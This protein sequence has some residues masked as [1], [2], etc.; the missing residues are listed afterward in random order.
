[1]EQRLKESKEKEKFKTLIKFFDPWECLKVADFL[2]KMALNGWGFQCRKGI[3][4]KFKKITPKKI[5]Y[6]VEPSDQKSDYYKPL[7]DFVEYCKAAG[8][9]FVDLNNGTY[10]FK[11]E[12][13]DVVSISTDDSLKFR[14]IKKK[15]RKELLNLTILCFALLCTFIL[16]PLASNSFFSDTLFS[17]RSIS[18]P[19]IPFFILYPL[20]YFF[21]YKKWFNVNKKRLAANLNLIYPYEKTDLF[22]KVVNFIYLLFAFL[23]MFFALVQQD[24][25]IMILSLI[26]GFLIITGIFIFI[27]LKKSE[28]SDVFTYISTAFMTVFLI[29]CFFFISVLFSLEDSQYGSEFNGSEINLKEEALI[30]DKDTEQSLFSNKESSTIS[31]NEG[32]V[33]LVI[34]V[35]NS[36]YKS[37]M[38]LCFAELT[39]DTNI[40]EVS[41]IPGITKYGL[42]KEHIVLQSDD[43]IYEI[44]YYLPQSDL[45]DETTI[46]KIIASF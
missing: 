29:L 13:C 3:F 16:F 19:V 1:M 44:Y 22:F 6:A 23:F 17:I 33:L 5:R 25:S 30:L 37:L 36:S 26:S 42:E 41:T 15:T 2:E 4:Y 8:W 31:K 46:T 24:I 21:R 27:R 35:Y 14:T 7:G 9:E 40:K 20:G 12:N 38:N 39:K 45:L 11:T 34:N 28:A 18:I 32:D 10:F 43:K